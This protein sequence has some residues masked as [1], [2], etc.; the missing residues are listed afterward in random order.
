M[1]ASEL[2]EQ[3]TP[4]EGSKTP[5]GIYEAWDLVK[6]QCT[7]AYDVFEQTKRVAYRG[8]DGA[9]AAFLGRSRITRKPMNTDAEFQRITDQALTEYLGQG[10]AVRGN[11]IFVSGSRNSASGYGQLFVI[12]PKDTATFTWSSKYDD[13]I[14][15]PKMMQWSDV[16]PLP[17][18]KFYQD[19]L[20]ELEQYPE[21]AKNQ[22]LTDLIHLFDTNLD[23]GAWWVNR[24]LDA[25][26]S[27]PV[28]VKQAAQ[29]TGFDMFLTAVR[30]K[31]NHESV[32]KSFYNL[33]LIKFNPR[34]FIRDF[35]PQTGDWEQALK[36]RNEIY[37]SGEYVA[38]RNSDFEQLIDAMLYG[39]IE[40]KMKD[41]A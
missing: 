36:S 35:D 3:T 30:R 2:I 41:L 15:D 19:F 5:L 4:T 33:G 1:R 13:L 22:E 17:K 31:Q 40:S 23:Y 12:F 11:S 32:M 7:N 18:M 9:P 10:A 6:T 14:L 38:I 26:D 20:D 8:L 29:K 39:E 25:V 27:L 24:T 21:L 37:V 34:K 16:I 28:E